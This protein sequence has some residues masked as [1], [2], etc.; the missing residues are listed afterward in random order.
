MGLVILDYR[1]Q[2]SAFKNFLVLDII[3]GISKRMKADIVMGNVGLLHEQVQGRSEETLK[4]DVEWRLE[5]LEEKVKKSV[6]LQ[7]GR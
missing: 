4:R 3:Y 1:V 6:D 2:T 7:N 5:Q